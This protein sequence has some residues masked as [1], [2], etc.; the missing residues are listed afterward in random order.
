MQINFSSEESYSIL[1]Y[2][3]A[4]TSKVSCRKDSSE[5][6]IAAD[7]ASQFYWRTFIKEKIN[8]ARLKGKLFMENARYHLLLDNDK[9]N[10]IGCRPLVH[11][12]S[13][14]SEKLLRTLSKMGINATV[15]H[16]S[17]DTESQTICVV[18]TQDPYK[19][20]IEIGTTSTVITT[21]EENVASLIYK[22]VDNI[23]DLI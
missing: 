7:L 12:S 5:L 23:L 18:H 10:A 2:T 6:K 16:R 11:W 9:K 15:E 22:A 21:A 19:A 1:H 14:D 4:E 8:I 3:E 20:L 13:P 17:S